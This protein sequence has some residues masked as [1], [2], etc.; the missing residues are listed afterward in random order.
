M[1]DL[2]IRGIVDGAIL[3]VVVWILVRLVPRLG[4]TCRTT[5]W[6][7]V[8]AK[9]VVPLAW[10]TPLQLPLL[11]APEPLSPIEVSPIAVAPPGAMPSAAAIAGASSIDWTI[12][13]VVLWIAGVF[14][15][16][17]VGAKQWRERRRAIRFSDPADVSVQRTLREIAGR[18]KIRRVPR[19]LTC[20]GTRSPFITG[21]LRPVIVIP[22]RFSALSPEQQRMALCHELAHVKRGDLWLGIVPALA[23]RVFFFHPLARLA[24][25]EYVFWREV[26][27][28]AAVLTALATAPQAY[29]RLLLDLGVAAGP[30]TLAPAGAAWSFDSLK[31]RIVMLQRPSTPSLRIRVAA[32]GISI[33]ALTG[34]V[35]FRL[36]ARTP[37][38]MV[39]AVEPTAAAQPA[40]IGPQLRAWNPMEFLIRAARGQQSKAETRRE[41]Q[42]GFVFLND[43]NTTMSGSVADVER[44][45]RQRTAGEDLLWFRRNGIE[46]VVRDPALLREVTRIW[47][48]VSAIG[49]E[50]SAIGARQSAIGARQ[51][52]IG[53]RQSIVGAAQSA[54][55]ARQS[56]IAA[57]QSALAT[58]DRLSDAERTELARQM[59]SLDADMRA[60]DR[61]MA[62]LD[63][64]MRQLDKPMSDLGDDMDALGRQ[65]DALGRKMD[66]AQQKAEAEMGALIERAIASGAARP[67]R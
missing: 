16:L 33:L 20:H 61:Q 31:R 49:N 54:I 4:P 67:V 60:L 28:D 32:I 43:E 19:I 9:F 13:L 55:G 47:G 59:R 1:R 15:S 21:V 18:L 27:C 8:A 57:R 14:V 63:A 45:R 48:Q 66:E 7:I 42:T 17:A 35:P 29:G 34:L 22:A 65:M 64:K 39:P 62:E 36:V 41:Q 46:Y 11:P 10:I 40:R 58:R 5:L 6:W 44:A 38:A 53:A 3:A 56:E 26:A 37:A 52:E 12:V 30:A 2:L 24:S 23:E 25:R 50:Q 51:S